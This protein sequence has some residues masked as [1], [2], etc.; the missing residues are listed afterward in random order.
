MKSINRYKVLI[1]KQSGLFGV[2]HQEEIWD[3]SSPSLLGQ[4][5]TMELL[6]KY[7]SE[8]GSQILSL[9]DPQELERYE[10]REAEL[11]VN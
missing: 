9:K 10:L 3:S 1:N 11:I 8:G 5:V 4:T 6:K 7:A 2:F